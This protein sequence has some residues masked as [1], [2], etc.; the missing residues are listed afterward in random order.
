MIR[1]FVNID[2]VATVREARKTV[3]PDPLEAALLAEKAGAYGITA[4]LRED[5][6]HVQD[7][8]IE[9]LKEGIRTPLNLEMAAVEEMVQIALKVRPHQVSLV[10]EKRQ[11]I[12]TEGGLDACSQESHLTAVGTRLKP[13][14]ILFSLFIDPVPAQVEAAKRAGA[15]SIEL[16]TG[17]Y[18]ESRSLEET[19]RHLAQIRQASAQ[20]S[21][22]GLRVFAGHGLTNENVV[23]VAAVPAIEELNIGH[24]IV[25][26]SILAGMERSVKDMLISIQK[27]VDLRPH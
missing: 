17:P 24:H 6:R 25:S 22:M 2:H 9:R 10:P 4:H 18:S 21:G 3:E 23:A 12:T 15:D 26:R 11:E 5:R 14:G 27:G 8:D 13:Q 1:L 7:R 16:N 20:A 19:E